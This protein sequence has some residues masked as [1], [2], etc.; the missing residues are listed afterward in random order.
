MSAHVRAQPFLKSLWVALDRKALW[1]LSFLR[2]VRPQHRGLRYGRHWRLL[3]LFFFSGT[4]YVYTSELEGQVSV[5]MSLTL[6][7]TDTTG[8][9]STWF[10]YSCVHR[11]FQPL[12]AVQCWLQKRSDILNLSGGQGSWMSATAS[13]DGQ[14]TSHCWT[15]A[16][17]FLS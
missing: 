17:L 1:P 4:P 14:R 6:V 10:W 3:G 2:C 8:N 12:A 5:G 9:T 16:N 7:H 15:G 13:T 11:A